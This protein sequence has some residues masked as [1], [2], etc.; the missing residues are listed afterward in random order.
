[1]LE[2]LKDVVSVVW[3]TR[4]T[5]SFPCCSHLWFSFP[6]RLLLLFGFLL[7]LAPCADGLGDQDLLGIVPS[8]LLGWLWWGCGFGLAGSCFPSALAWGGSEGCVPPAGLAGAHSGL[9][10]AE[11]VTCHRHG[12]EVEFSRELSNY[13]WHV[14]VVGM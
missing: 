1:M 11:N 14:C 10:S 3:G 12:M 8:L 4:G 7:G 6:C 9:P 5:G 2:H 13:S